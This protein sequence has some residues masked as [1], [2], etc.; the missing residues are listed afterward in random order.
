MFSYSSRLVEL[1]A[2]VS[3]PIS[4]ICK[5]RPTY[6]IL[7]WIVSLINLRNT[8]LNRNNLMQEGIRKGKKSFVINFYMLETNHF[9]LVWLNF[10]YPF[11]YHWLCLRTLCFLFCVSIFVFQNSFSSFGAKNNKYTRCFCLSPTTVILL[12][13][14]PSHR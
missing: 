7:I 6:I 10:L 5:L 8:Y 4:D 12:L 1:L 9:K 3:L 14:H 2:S 13:V 11:K